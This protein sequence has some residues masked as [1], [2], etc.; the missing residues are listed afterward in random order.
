ML[1]FRDEEHVDRWCRARELPRGTLVSPPT[2][3]LLARGWYEHKLTPDWRRHTTAEAEALFASL[4][5]TGEFWNLRTE[6]RRLSSL[7]CIDDSID[8]ERS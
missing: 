2:A 1:L 3:W 8:E 4:G 6:G 7:N 5:L